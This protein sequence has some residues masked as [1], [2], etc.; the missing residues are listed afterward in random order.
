MSSK[1][2]AWIASIWWVCSPAIAQKADVEIGILTCTLDEPSKAPD[3]TAPNIESQVREAVCTFKPK[4]G[5]EE[6]YAGI[7][8]GVSLTPDKTKAV[9]WI[10]K[11]D[12]V[13]PSAPGLLQQ[14]YA[15]DR[16]TPADQLPPLVGL[17]TIETPLR[18][19]SSGCPRDLLNACN[20]GH[21]RANVGITGKTHS[22]TATED[23]ELARRRL[24]DQ[25]GAI[26]GKDG[27]RRPGSR[28]RGFK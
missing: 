23:I 28:E 24:Q 16:A 11:A 14:N 1:R 10:V 19:P 8:Q 13:M 2:L 26:V 5:A 21:S 17:I 27:P 12:T 22:Q 25:H 7:V 18:S 4:S 15:R 3:T 6:I 20:A 9:I